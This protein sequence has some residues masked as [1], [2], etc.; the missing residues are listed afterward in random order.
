MKSPVYYTFHYNADVLPRL[1]YIDYEIEFVEI[2]DLDNDVPGTGLTFKVYRT[3]L[4]HF[5]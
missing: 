5:L 4:H 2:G 3:I 1:D